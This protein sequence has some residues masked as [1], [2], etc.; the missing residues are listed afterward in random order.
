MKNFLLIRISIY[1]I[2]LFIV[3]WIVGCNVWQLKEANL[4]LEK[5]EKSDL[6]VKTSKNYE[7]GKLTLKFTEEIPDNLTVALKKDFQIL[8]NNPKSGIYYE[9]D[10]NKKLFDEN[11]LPYPN[12]KILKYQNK[13]HIIQEGKLRPIDDKY[14]IETLNLKK[15]NLT[16]LEIKES[17]NQSI[18]FGE[19][20]TYAEIQKKFPEKILINKNGSLYLTVTK[21]YRQ[22]YIPN[23]QELI[24]KYDI[25][26]I[27]T[28]SQSNIGKCYKKTKD[29]LE[30]ICDF[31]LNKNAPGNIYLAEISPSNS[32][33]ESSNLKLTSDLTPLEI[34]QAIKDLFIK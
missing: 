6:F 26:T 31:N 29:S 30:I 16:K 15:N 34:W 32:N 17:E 24:E 23:I 18:P 33:L 7:K 14:F 11:P 21:G 22:I 9:K 5:S 4:P 12:G 8:L 27:E 25:Q 1:L 28:S 13:I 2:G 3:L 10:L 20:L 19:T